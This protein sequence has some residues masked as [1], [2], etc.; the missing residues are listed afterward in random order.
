[1]RIVGKEEDWKLTQH[2]SPN[3]HLVALSNYC[4]ITMT[5]NHVY[6]FFDKSKRKQFIREEQDLALNVETITVLMEIA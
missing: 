4:Q 5:H 1:M 2:F 3:S 6:V